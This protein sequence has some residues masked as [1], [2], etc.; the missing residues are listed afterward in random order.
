MAYLNIASYK[1]VEL[2]EPFLLKL[3]EALQRTAAARGI[4]GT[5]LL[6][7]E[8]INLFLAGESEA[9]KAFTSYLV[10]LPEFADLQFKFSES[11]NIPFKRLLVRI[12]KE[13]ITMQQD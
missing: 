13:I 6:S 1:F 8:G 12:K 7:V 10:S 11:S 9:I 4:K 5:I 2:P 3:R